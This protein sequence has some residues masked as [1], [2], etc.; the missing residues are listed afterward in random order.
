MPYENNTPIAI[1][2]LVIST[3][4]APSLSLRDLRHRSIEYVIKPVIPERLRSHPVMDR[5][6]DRPDSR[7]VF[8]NPTG[9][10][11]V[12]GPKA[13]LMGRKIILDTY[14]GL[15]RH[16]GRGFSGKDPSRADRS[17]ASVAW[18]CACVEPGRS[19]VLALWTP[20]PSPMLTP[21]ATMEVMGNA[22]RDCR[23]VH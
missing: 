16:G 15:G 10:F 6:R 2:N 8:V 3:Y 18:S 14:G 7:V 13:G 12:G 1:A 21:L 19:S 5:E 22:L 9:A 11:L 17:A 23:T 4:H 20:V